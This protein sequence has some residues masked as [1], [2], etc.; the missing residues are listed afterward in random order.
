MNHWC[1]LRSLLLDDLDFLCGF[2]HLD[3]AWEGTSEVEILR[4]P[5]QRVISLT[6]T[7]LSF[8]THNGAVTLPGAGDTKELR[9][10]REIQMYEQGE[11]HYM[12]CGR[13]C[14]IYPPGR[15]EFHLGWGK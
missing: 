10:H 12:G 6:C 8:T 4:R 1:N 14:W 15:G 7:I 11:T 13:H 9:V 3:F 2:W 5:G